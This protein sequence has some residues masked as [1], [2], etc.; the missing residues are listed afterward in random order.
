MPSPDIPAELVAKMQRAEEHITALLVEN[1]DAYFQPAIYSIAIEPDDATGLQ[2]TAYIS[3]AEPLPPIFAIRI[4]EAL[5]QLRSVLDHTVMMLS[6]VPP[7]SRKTEFVVTDNAN[8]FYGRNGRPALNSRLGKIR[9]PEARSFIEAVQ[10]FRHHTGP[11]NSPL[12]VLHE[13][14][15]ADKHRRLLLTQA[16]SHGSR[17]IPIYPGVRNISFVSGGLKADATGR[18]ALAM[19]TLLEPRPRIDLDIRPMLTV[20]F[21]DEPVA[22]DR[23]VFDVLEEVLRFTTFVVGHLAQFL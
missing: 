22:R 23:I 3:F 13:L 16:G 17:R 7:T 10:P 14:F 19:L 21:A 15:M 2:H 20:A 12:W 18:A 8:S 5:Y 1:T 11:E 9:S 6:D 4:G